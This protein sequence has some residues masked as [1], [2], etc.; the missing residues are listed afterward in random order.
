[1]ADVKITDL[2]TTSI[3]NDTDYLVVDDG[4]TTYKAQKSNIVNSKP[5]SFV[6]MVVQGT[7]LT[8]LLSVQEIYGTDTTWQLLSD[9][10]VVSRNVYGN[11]K[12][13]GLTSG[14]N[15]LGLS[16]DGGDDTAYS[17][18]VFGKSLP[19]QQS[20][21]TT[22]TSGTGVGLLTKT[23][24]DDTPDNTGIIVDTVAVYFWERTL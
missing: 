15:K 16:A 19:I 7:N 20:G 10:L 1:M 23:L 22:L 9:V 12:V 11:G 4:N 18:N 13:M 2:P 24:A 21:V 8:S 17:T 6:G 3:V 14:S 5:F